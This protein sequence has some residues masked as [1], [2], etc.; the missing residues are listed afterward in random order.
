MDRQTDLEID[1]QATYEYCFTNQIHVQ[2]ILNELAD[3]VSLNKFVHD[4]VMSVQ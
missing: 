2:C 3:R 4:T 1:R